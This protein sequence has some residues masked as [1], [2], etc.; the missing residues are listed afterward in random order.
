M[1]SVAARSAA[2][3]I[4]WRPV[5]SLTATALI[6]LVVAATWVA[7]PI[8]GVALTASVPLLAAATAYLLDE[9][10][11]EAVAATPTTLR[12]RSAGRL[13]FAVVVW[14]LGALGL[15]AL[16][17]R[18]GTAARVGVIAQ[19]TGCI[20]LAVAASAA[21]RRRTAEP[22]EAVAAALVGAVL[23]LAVANPL[24]RWVD[25]FPTEPGQ[26]WGGSLAVWSV[27]AVA[28]VVTTVRATRDPLD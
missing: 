24:A 16:A 2:M 6:L 14:A 27:I 9:A 7:S 4:P 23:C 12:A 1:S 13:V 15:V 21:L 18:S 3:G 8:A 28:C 19:V 5:T 26:R 17:M 25:L 22:G 10:A 11:S 20:L